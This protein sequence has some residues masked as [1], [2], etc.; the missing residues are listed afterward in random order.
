[1]Q[2][3]FDFLE[4]IVRGYAHDCV[5]SASFFVVVDYIASSAPLF[6]ADYIEKAVALT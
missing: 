2:N 6:A 1:M 3:V 4:H 5:S